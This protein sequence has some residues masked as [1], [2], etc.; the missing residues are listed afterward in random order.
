LLGVNFKLQLCIQQELILNWCWELTDKGV[1]E[2]LLYCQRLE[3]LSLVGV[4]RI[5][6]SILV[7]VGIVLPELKLLN[8]EQCPNID[9]TNLVSF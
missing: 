7:D 6:E 5:T 8:L 3:E 9:D 4:V 1:E 2:V